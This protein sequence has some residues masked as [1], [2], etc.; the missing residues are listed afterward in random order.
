MNI[1]WKNCFRIGISAFILFIC[2]YNWKYMEG[3]LGM[4]CTAVVPLVTGLIIAYVINIL[5]SFYEKH[6]FKKKADRKVVQKSRRP[7]CLVAAMVTLCCI[8]TLVIWLVI[9]ELISCVKFLIAEIPPA[10]ELL[11]QSKWVKT[12]LPT[13]ILASLADIDWMKTITEIVEKF[14]SGF[15][16][17]VNVVLTAVSSIVSSVVNFFIGIIFAIYLMFDKERLQGQCRRLIHRCLNHKWEENVLHWMT[18]LNDSFHKFIVGQCTEAVILG[19]LCTVGMLIFRFPY[20]GMIGALIGFLALIPIVGAFIGAGVGFVMIFTVSPVQAV[21]FLIFIVVLQQIEGNLIYPK[22]VGKSVGLPAIWTL[23]AVTIGGS[24]L[25]IPGVIV[26]V[27]ITSALY[28]L[29]RED[30]NKHELMSAK[31]NS[32]LMTAKTE[33]EQLTIKT[34]KKSE[35]GKSN[36]KQSD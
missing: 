28:R 19:S 12:V 13:D 11:L 33:N 9:P 34:S 5:M 2:I 31:M 26:G 1:S 36:K 24:L 23:A 25:G 17:A 20:S 10:I 8:I 22:V 7:V 4:I 27:P 3:F 18:V 14:S 35:K 32:K 29:L 16:D 21:L 6:Y 15:G 30:L